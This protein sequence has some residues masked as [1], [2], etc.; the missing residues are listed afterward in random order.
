MGA[1]M[2][3]PTRRPLQGADGGAGLPAGDARATGGPVGEWA[4]YPSDIDVLAGWPRRV[5][6]DSISGQSTR[7]VAH[8]TPAPQRPHPPS[9]S[10]VGVLVVD[11]QAPFLVAARRLI[12]STPGFEAVGEATSGEGAVTLAAALR[13]DLVL[14]DV[15]MPGLGGLAAARCIT[16]ARSASAVVLVST[17]PQDVP[18]AAAEGCGAL[19]VISKQHLRPS[20]LAALWERCAAEASASPPD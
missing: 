19:A 6:P 16:A 4:R 15:R 17:D 13:P 14:M 18:A 7:P 5:C 8:P 9:P 1:P 20:K 11:D 3:E 12:E 10:T 2:R